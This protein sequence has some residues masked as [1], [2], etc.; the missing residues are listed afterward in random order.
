MAGSSKGP[1]LLVGSRVA[2][3]K[4]RDRATVRYI[5]PVDGQQGTWI[6][7]EWDD[8]SRGKHD[9]SAGGRKYFDV[10]SGTTA[11]SFVRA[12]KVQAG[13]SLLSALRARYNNETAEGA[14]G[15]GITRAVYLDT[16]SSRKVLVELV[17]EEQ[18]TERQRKTQL[19][20]RARVVDAGVSCMVGAWI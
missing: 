9:G 2:I 6:G 11:G 12:E 20:T 16:R 18:V 19:L 10:T 13:A 17:G 5:G 1:A 14:A 8:P 15:A 7:V 3:G 4:E